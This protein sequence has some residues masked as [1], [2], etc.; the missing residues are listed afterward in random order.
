MTCTY[1][2]GGDLFANH[3]FQQVRYEMESIHCRTTQTEWSRTMPVP[4]FSQE[5]YET[6]F[7]KRFQQVSCGCARVML[8][9]V[10]YKVRVVTT[11]WWTANI[12]IYVYIHTHTNIYIYIYDYSRWIHITRMCSRYQQEDIMEC[13][14]GQP[15]WRSRSKKQKLQSRGQGRSRRRWGTEQPWQLWVGSMNH[16][17]V[18][19]LSHFFLEGWLD[20]W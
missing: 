3:F 18:G 7:Q 1:A 4:R 14:T 19:L 9:V 12:P 10:I 16:R 8:D 2:G 6:A 13:R 5:D 15:P 17:D 20:G 11:G